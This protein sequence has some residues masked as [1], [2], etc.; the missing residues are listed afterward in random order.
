MKASYQFLGGVAFLFIAALVFSAMR[1]P[2]G[3][4]TAADWAAA[5][6]NVAVVIASLY[7]AGSEQRNR[8]REET[9]K[10]ESDFRSRQNLA[11]HTLEYNARASA[12]LCRSSANVTPKLN[13]IMLRALSAQISLH[14]AAIQQIDP[15]L[16]PPIL[17]D[18]LYGCSLKF[19]LIITWCES[20]AD[21]PEFITQFSSVLE[22]C[23][24]RLSKCCDAIYSHSEN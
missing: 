24:T 23:A 18:E 22:D 11:L 13:T 9:E 1:H 3:F 21:K 7:L 15:G 2:Q 17:K 20:V 12:S 10:R 14:Q 8:Y 6:A 4:G 16:L 5:G 19:N